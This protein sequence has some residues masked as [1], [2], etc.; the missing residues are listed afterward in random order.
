MSFACQ[1]LAVALS[2]YDSWTT[3]LFARKWE[4]RSLI[5]SLAFIVRAIYRSDTGK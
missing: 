5:E 4:E 3:P 2:M 1:L